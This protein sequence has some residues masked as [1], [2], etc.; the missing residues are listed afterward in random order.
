MKVSWITFAGVY[1]DEL[2]NLTS[3]LAS[4][5][6]RVLAA[7]RMLP[8]ATY[9][10]RIVAITKPPTD[11][12]IA[13]ALDADLVIFSKSMHGSNEDLLRRA[14]AQKIRIVFDI[15]D[16]HFHHPQ[17]G[18]HYRF[19][20]SNA[21]QVVCNTPSM[22]KVAA[23]FCRREPIVIED[24]YEGPKGAYTD[25]AAAPRLLWFG[26]PS[27]LDS[28]QGCLED[29]I[30]YSKGHPLS[31]HVLTQVTPQHAKTAHALNAA[32]SP[33]FEIS[34]EEWSL[35][36]QWDALRACDI[37]IIP[38]LQNEKKQVKSANRMIEALWAGRPVV[39]QSMP[40]Y[41]AFANWAFIRPTISEG[42]AQLA[43][44]RDRISSRISDAQAYIEDRYSPTLI[45]AQ[46]RRLIDQQA[47]EG[48]L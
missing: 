42:L 32:H 7:I 26:H 13:A 44:E 11:D 23:S 6:Y 4:L 16:N 12:K 29:L 28:L 21:D 17:M 45:G 38:S 35:A 18:A 22:A 47:A 40:A 10:S 27:N 2:G 48:P 36:A 9:Q 3:N 25:L 15:C 14:K 5:R 39:A 30:G 43:A 46:W 41:A 1:R 31:L 20:A 19:M 8:T 34:F 24:P 37:V 33:H